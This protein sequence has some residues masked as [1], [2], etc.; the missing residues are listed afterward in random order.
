MIWNRTPPRLTG[1][2]WDALLAAVTEHFAWEHELEPPAWVHEP[3]RFFDPAWLVTDLPKDGLSDIDPERFTPPAFRRHGTWIDP[4][5]LDPRWGERYH[6][7]RGWLNT[8]NL[9]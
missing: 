1:T 4:C 7:A 6:W 9:P 2:R 3:E 5:S 8:W